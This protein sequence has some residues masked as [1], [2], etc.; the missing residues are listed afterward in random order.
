MKGYSPERIVCAA[1]LGGWVW[2]R[3]GRVD[4]DVDADADVDVDVWWGGGRGGAARLHSLE[5]WACGEAWR[6][7]DG[8]PAAWR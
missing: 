5:M 1:G 2:L 6:Q 4:A 8:S 3:C 7:C